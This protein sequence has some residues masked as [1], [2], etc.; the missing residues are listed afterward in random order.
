MPSN[1]TRT[2][3]FDSIYAKESCSD[4]ENFYLVWEIDFYKDSIKNMAEMNRDKG[5][6]Y[7]CYQCYMLQSKNGGAL[8]GEEQESSKDAR[9]SKIKIEMQFQSQFS[10]PIKEVKK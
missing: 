1:Y 2:P 7:H 5:I 8:C 6:C 9:R 10:S 3:F 4:K